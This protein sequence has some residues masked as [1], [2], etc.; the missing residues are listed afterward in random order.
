M[1]VPVPSQAESSNAYGFDRVGAAQ[2][3][4]LR[5]RGTVFAQSV[6]GA[7]RV[8]DFSTGAG[9]EA[10]YSDSGYDDDDGGNA[11]KRGGGVKREYNNGQNLGAFIRN[12]NAPGGRN[13][14]AGATVGA[15]AGVKSEKKSGDSSD[16]DDCIMVSDSDTGS[17]P[18]SSSS[19]SSSAS[20]SAS[21]SASPSGGR[22]KSEV[23]SEQSENSDGNARR[24]D[25]TSVNTDT[26]THPQE[27]DRDN[28][29]QEPAQNQWSLGD[30]NDYANDDYDQEQQQEQEHE[31]FEQ[32]Q[33]NCYDYNDADTVTRTSAAQSGASPHTDLRTPLDR[34][35]K[36]EQKNAQQQQH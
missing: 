8:S 9:A 26:E 23:K 5:A 31:Q 2:P 33:R 21:A 25:N 28:G 3:S 36:Q 35:V 18:H 1:P 4:L 27:Q 16:P 20:A 29:D 7:D 34:G 12:K 11:S 6:A 22:V 10:E 30:Y 15:D 32:K 19:S 24:T 13:N 17:R 14:E